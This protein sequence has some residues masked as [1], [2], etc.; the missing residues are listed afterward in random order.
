MAIVRDDEAGASRRR[1]PEESM[2]GLVWSGAVGL[3][4]PLLWV[5]CSSDR[6][7]AATGV[8]DA[9][10]AVDFG[11]V[12]LGRSVALPLHLRNVGVAP[13]TVNNVQ[14]QQPA[15]VDFVV[16][17]A[18]SVTLGP[19]ES[20]D[21]T[22]HFAPASVGKRA[23]GLLIG[24][25]STRT[26]TVQVD[27]E[28]IGI[29]AKADFGPRVLDFG[30]VAVESSSTLPL[31]F[32]NTSDDQ[33]SVHV[34]DLAGNDANAFVAAPAGDI[35]VPPH[36]SLFVNVRFGPNRQG[37]Y[38]VTLPVQACPSCAFE[39]VV[40]LGEGISATFAVVPSPLDFGFVAPG[41]TVTKTVTVTNLGTRIATLKGV[42]VVGAAFAAAALPPGGI[43]LAE[44]QGTTISVS[45]TPKDFGA[46]RGSLHVA[47]DDDGSPVILVPLTAAG[48]GPQISVLPNP[49]AFP[50]TAVGMAVQKSVAVRNVGFDPRNLLPLQLASYVVTGPAFAVTGAAAPFAL[51][52]GREGYL[53]VT[54]TPP[55]EGKFTGTLVINSND[56][57]NPQVVVTLEGSAS[58]LGPCSY[59]VVPPALVFG[60]V[61]EGKNAQLA[62]GVRNVGPNQCAVANVRLGAGTSKEFGLTP[63]STRLVNPGEL[64][65][66]PVEFAPTA[67]GPA[68]GAVVFDVSSPTAPHATVPLDAGGV[69]ACLAVE[70]PTLAFGNVGLQCQPPKLS[71]AV[72]NECRVPVDIHRSFVGPGATASFSLDPGEGGA[73]TLGPGQ[74]TLL[75]VTYAPK[76]AGDDSA[77]LFIDTSLAAQPFLVGLEGKA[78]TRPIQSDTFVQPLMAKVDVLWIVDNSGSMSDKQADLAA[79]A[80]RFIQAAKASASDFHIAI[81]TTGVVSNPGGIPGC[82][83]GADGGEAGRFYPVDN[84]NPRILTR[85]TPNLD[86]VFA[87]DVQVGICHFIEEGLTA[88][89]LALSTPLVDHADAPNTP[90][91]ND[92]NA[93]FLRPDAVLYVINVQDE[94]DVVPDASNQEGK[95]ANPVPVPH[96][97]SFLRGLK[98]GRPDLLAYTAVVGLPGSCGGHIDGVGRRFIE[99]AQEVGGDVVDICASDWGATLDNIAQKAFSPRTAFPLS[100]PPDG[101]DLSLT[102]D[103]VDF[104][105]TNPD[106]S[107]NWTFDPL[108]GL[109]GTVVF[110]P[111][112]APGPN[113]TTVITYAAM[114]P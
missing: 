108:A 51:G 86:Q 46:Q 78:L 92:G 103:G 56:P 95:S 83:G 21:A 73:Q 90:P 52:A 59:Q 1:V 109:Y 13:L 12:P 20:V 29:L 54:F 2:R 11:R 14:P 113:T 47:T 24:T 65:L 81:T 45:F 63:M 105:P 102:V 18:G 39:N 5:G 82:P 40:L 32:T 33:A 76:V 48:T 38:D 19:G 58:K 72:R 27:S 62:F 104:P 36:Q 23:C 35:K 70:P 3:V 66:V 44:N 6:T 94:E 55:A 98:P 17:A 37:K 41:T 43:A 53:A 99:F 75:D 110:T 101:R 88:M 57:V 93:G 26:P 71:V 25:D 100:R 30:K 22:V 84:S 89:E 10:P 114:C 28:G 64:L 96:Y 4:M 50:R 87:A 85:A 15:P 106:G 69:A 67:P 60:S 79:N 9:V 74:E 7:H 111:G 8:L 112:V 16:E 34:G 80:N 107:V 68:T 77:P 42:Q 49:L 97:A 91:P 31:A 61:D